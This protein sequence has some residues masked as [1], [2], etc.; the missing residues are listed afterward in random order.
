MTSRP[1]LLKV[2][3]VAELLQLSRAKVYILIQEKALRAVK[4]GSN[5][6]IKADVGELLNASVN[7]GSQ[8]LRPELES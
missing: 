3:E 2:S 6:R 8:D 5:W 7:R 4:I 1:A